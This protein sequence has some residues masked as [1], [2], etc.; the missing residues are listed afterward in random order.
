MTLAIEHAY[1]LQAKNPSDLD[2]LVDCAEKIGMQP[3][4]FRL[5]LAETRESGRLES[6]IK[7]ARRMGL[8]SFPSFAVATKDSFVPIE[9]DY[10]NPK[11]MASEI[12]QAL[13]ELV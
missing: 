5:A 8:N 9:L 3:E 13:S 12:K 10:K 6:E 1:Y 2:T 11:K 4:R 7:E